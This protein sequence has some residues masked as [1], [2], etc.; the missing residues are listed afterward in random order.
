[1]NKLNYYAPINQT[2]YGVCSLN[3]LRE[4]SKKY[5]IA[6]FPIGGISIDNQED[7]EIILNTIHMNKKFCPKAPCF[8]LWHQFDLASRIGVGEYFSYSFF[9]IDKL[10]DIDKNHLETPHKIFTSSEWYK[11]ILIQNDIK[12][13][14]F[15]AA[16]GVNRNIFNM[17]LYD[18]NNTDEEFYSFI[19]IGKWEIRKGHDILYSIFQ[20]AFPDEKD[21]RLTI[22]A[23]EHTSS[24]SN[25]EEVDKWKKM[26]SSDSRIN[27]IP[28]VSTHKNIADII[29]KHNCGIF[30]SRAEGWNLEL[31]ECMSMNK[32]VIATNYS[33]HT[34]FC[35]NDN[36]HLVDIDDSEKAYDGK[37]FKGQGNWAKISE[38]QIDQVVEYMRICY[39]NRINANIGGVA[40]SKKYS[41]ENTAD[42][43]S[44][45]IFN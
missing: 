42:I 27:V 5:D 40:T 41:W 30:I 33:A 9:E 26:Y 24:Y 4:L 16:P 15:V 13:E 2:G 11:N 7:Q 31:L 21:V 32:P 3:I 19:N 35:N 10:N 44:R 29:S 6:F 38:K 23:A 34:E 20:K 36:C 45:C 22:V 14:I 12:Q 18:T 17:D 37:A 1:M 8:K 43:I 39:K 25:K 28:G